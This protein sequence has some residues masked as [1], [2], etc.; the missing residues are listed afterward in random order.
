MPVGQKS[1]TR[2]PHQKRQAGG[3][4]WE[5]QWQWKT[6]WQVRVCRVQLC[7]GSDRQ[8]QHTHSAY[9]PVLSVMV[10]PVRWRLGNA[11]KEEEEEE[12]EVLWFPIYPPTEIVSVHC[13]FISPLLDADTSSSQCRTQNN[14]YKNC[15]ITSVFPVMLTWQIVRLFLSLNRRHKTTLEHFC[16]CWSQ[17]ARKAGTTPPHRCLGSVTG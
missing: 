8:G 4:G 9:L 17:F 6:V 13:E 3:S 5:H 11:K 1:G 14:N 2:P 12:G 10:S 7:E 15:H 16:I